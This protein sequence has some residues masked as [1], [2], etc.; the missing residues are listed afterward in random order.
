MVNLDRAGLQVDGFAV[1]SEIIGAL[2]LDLDGG[3]LRRGLLDQAGES[4]QQFPYSLRRRSEVAGLDGAALG[5]VGVALLAPGDREAI[6]LA[7]VHHERNRL[8]GF[9]ER[10]RQ[11]AGGGRVRGGGGGGAA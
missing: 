9:A 3:V 6:A 10:D 1:A 7:T 11:G 8:G 2:A 4:R 5:I